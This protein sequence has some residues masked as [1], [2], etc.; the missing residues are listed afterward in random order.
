MT[1]SARLSSRRSRLALAGILALT[2]AAVAVRSPAGGTG[3]DVTVYELPSVQ[4][5]GAAGGIR[6]YSVGTTSCNIGD[7]PLWWCDDDRTYCDSD[8]HPVIAQNLYRL[9][10][11]RFEQLGMSWLKHGFLALS[12]PAAD[13]RGGIC[14]SPPHGGDQLGVGCTDPYSSGLNGN[15]P[16]GLRSEVNGATGDFP[17]P[18][19][20][21]PSPLVIDQRLQVAETELDPALNPGAR[22]WVEGHYIAA[23]DARFENGLNNASYREVSVSPG[24]FNLNNAGPTVRQA[25]ALYAWQAVDP[26]VEIVNA[27]VVPSSP[28]QRFEVGRNVTP[29]GGGWHYE[30]AIH[31]LNSDRSARSFTVQ[32]PPGSEISNAG[33]RDVE[34]HSGEPYSTADWDIAID[35]A[36]GTISWSTDTFDVD[37]FANAL[38]WGTTFSFWFDADAA[39]AGLGH[40]LDLFKPGS[41]S[42]IEV[43]FNTLIFTD[44]F[45]SGDTSAW[46]QSTP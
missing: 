3:P 46:S 7:E 12:I 18:Y 20:I 27:D 23:D 45:E 35:G 39:P 38:R 25:S 11:G 13:C 29:I 14:E 21:V 32:L 17:F 1:M 15:R 31:N 33:F 36:A 9:K 8:Q 30:Y 6:A 19:T 26:T 22:F 41:P 37:E 16:L 34:H 24:S 4:N 44:G 5:W 28:V 43:P 42:V 40:T 2:L 10:D